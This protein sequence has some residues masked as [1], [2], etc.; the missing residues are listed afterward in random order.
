MEIEQSRTKCTKYFHVVTQT[1]SW[2]FCIL[3]DILN[4]YGFNITNNKNYFDFFV[5]NQWILFLWFPSNFFP[6]PLLPYKFPLSH[7]RH[8]V[9]LYVSQ[10]WTQTVYV[11]MKLRQY[12]RGWSIQQWVQSWRLCSHP[13][14]F[15]NLLGESWHQWGVPALNFM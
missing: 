13:H 8:F 15:Q 2:P 11:T 6:L 14:P 9:L 12:I 3:K 5:F 4:N 1:H 10:N 7:L